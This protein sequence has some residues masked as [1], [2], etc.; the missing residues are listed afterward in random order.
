MM[1]A[2]K[3]RDVAR[4]AGQDEKTSVAESERRHMSNAADALAQQNNDHRTHH[5]GVQSHPGYGGGGKSRSR[6]GRGE[7]SGL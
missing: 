2:E 1:R 4:D 7:S 6:N 3:E 5:G